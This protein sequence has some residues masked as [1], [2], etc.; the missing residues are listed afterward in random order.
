MDYPKELVIANA[1]LLFIF[2]NGGSDYEVRTSSTY[3]PL[4]D[5]FRL[6]LAQRE[7]FTEP[8]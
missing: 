3:K 6:T 4:A 2:K 5:Q 8:D 7:A 1:L